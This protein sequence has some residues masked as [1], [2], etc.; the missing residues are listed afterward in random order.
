LKYGFI[1]REV[2]NPEFLEHLHVNLSRYEHR[3]SSELAEEF[4]PIKEKIKTT[5]STD[6]M[7]EEVDECILTDGSDKVVLNFGDEASVFGPKNR[8]HLG[9]DQAC[10][11]VTNNGAVKCL[12]SSKT[13]GGK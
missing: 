1:R 10:E 2:K 11:S 12:T 8:H 9:G 7:A 4:E 3:T 13:E 5:C 6:V